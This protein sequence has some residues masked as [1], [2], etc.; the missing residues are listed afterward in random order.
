MLVTMQPPTTTQQ[1]YVFLQ[2]LDLLNTNMNVNIENIG[3][4]S[5]LWPLL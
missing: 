1:N 4:Q 2:L 3:M 5:M